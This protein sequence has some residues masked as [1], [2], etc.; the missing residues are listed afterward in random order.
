MSTTLVDQVREALSTNYRTLTGVDLDG[1]MG[2]T[3]REVADA[4]AFWTRYLA[5]FSGELRKEPGVQPIIA[6]A[7]RV[8]DRLGAL[9]ARMPEQGE[10]DY[11]TPEFRAAFAQVDEYVRDLIARADLAGD[12]NGVPTREELD[13]FAVGYRTHLERSLAL[14]TGRNAEAEAKVR[15][16]LDLLPQRLD[17]ARAAL[18]TP[19]ARAL[20]AVP[21]R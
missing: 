2:V 5:G 21:G 12:R 1:S 19:A 10:V 16:A 18:A 8:V 11:V 15:R 6:D 9:L 4:H 20:R 17:A 3:K 7:Q 14:A 13:K